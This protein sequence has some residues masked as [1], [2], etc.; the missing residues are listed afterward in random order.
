MPIVSPTCQRCPIAATRLMVVQPELPPT[1][2]VLFI[3]RDPGA[4]EDRTGRPLHPDA[5]AGGLLR[6]LIA[7]V[8]IPPE[9]CGF[10][11][12]VHCHT[13]NNKGP[14][15]EE[16]L[17]CKPWGTVVARS[18]QQDYITVMLGQEATEAVVNPTGYNPK[19]PQVKVGETFE[20][21]EGLYCVPHPS[22]A[23][24]NGAQRR[25]LRRRLKKVAD[26]LG[27]HRPEPPV[28]L[29]SHLPSKYAPV[30]VDVE[31]SMV[32]G[33]LLGVGLA[34]RQGGEVV[35]HWLGGTSGIALLRDWAAEAECVVMH[36]G[37]FDVRVLMREGLVFEEGVHDTYLMGHILRRDQFVGGLGL[38]ELAL[39]DLGLAWDTLDD[40]G[41]PEELDEETL[42]HYCLCDCS[43]TLLLAEKY[44][45]EME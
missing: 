15:K 4:V 28:H 38:K 41:P 23:L 39:A 34:W 29:V 32:D 24:R 10:D 9:W 33:H 14:K 22:A 8:G 44:L 35:N 30:A 13:V 17:A 11:N 26:L 6:S 31:T 1:L 37:K 18:I 27:I 16:V 19:K 7:D 21:R 2:R 3:G 20:I 5:P 25:E 12:V 43:A 40:L 45:E 36:N 42:S